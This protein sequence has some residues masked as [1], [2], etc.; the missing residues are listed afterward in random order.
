MLVKESCLLCNTACALEI[1]DLILRA[2][3]KIWKAPKWFKLCENFM[4][5]RN[6]IYPD[7]SVVVMGTS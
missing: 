1:L 4:I 6:E 5:C 2:R 3:S 7:V